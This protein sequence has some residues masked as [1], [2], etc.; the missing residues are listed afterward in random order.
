MVS[1]VFVT[2]LVLVL[3]VSRLADFAIGQANS[4]WALSRGAV[5]YDREQYPLL[6]G[7]WMLVYT[8]TLVEAWVFDADFVPW[9]GGPMVVV[10]LLAEAARWWTIATLGTGW[11]NRLIHWPDG[12]AVP[13][14]AAHDGP[15]RHLSRP[16]ELTGLVVG[17][18]LPLAHSAWVTALLFAVLYATVVHRRM[19]TEERM[20]GL[21]QMGL[22][23]DSADSSGSPIHPA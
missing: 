14:R 4:R 10:A 9:L 18:A 21:G 8:G 15:F 5:E 17:V 16:A 11:T 6:V 19:A 12:P 7:L 2:Q 20:P 22:H 13:A 23:P 1:L 3:A